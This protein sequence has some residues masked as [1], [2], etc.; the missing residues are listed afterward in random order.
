MHIF[1]TGGAGFIGSNLVEYHLSKGDKVHVVDDLSTGSLDNLKQFEGNSDLRFDEADVLTWE[2]LGQAAA[3]ADRIYHLAAV[4][5][6]FRV[7]EDPIKT[8]A[9][10]VAGCERLLRAALS[11][12]WSP[13]IV[14]ASTSEV[15]GTGI[16][17]A[18]DAIRGKE[19]ETEIDP[20]TI[21][22]FEE[23]M[24]PMVGSSAVSRWNYSIS[25]LCDEAFGMSY[26]SRMGMKV[27][28][29]RF[30]NTIGPRQ[31]G[32]YGMVVPRFV[33]K[34][35]AGE[36]I[37]VFGDGTQTRCFCDVRD[38][39][40]SLDALAKNPESYGKIVNVGN[41][42][43]ISILQLAELIKERAG[44]NSEIKFVP[45]EEA[46]TEVFQET[47]RRRPNLDR[48]RNLSGFEH[49]WSLEQTIDELIEVERNK[50]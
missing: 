41:E 45:Y 22:P 50:N 49:N 20:S 43:E 33:A 6:V 34:A 5:G 28:V 42:R 23:D 35:V 11:G 10:N 38:T 44:S 1:I 47:A 25:K 21:P 30:F 37:S 46:Y 36:P 40:A 29:V 32:R 27:I 26:A 16:H 39:V 2:G 15:Y 7:L 9:T 12:E 14:I 17:Y 4:V 48:F 13:E 19:G 31:T 24:E 3:W 8:L 18:E